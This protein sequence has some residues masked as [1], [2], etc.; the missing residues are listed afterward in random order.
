MRGL[1]KVMRILGKNWNFIATDVSQEKGGNGERIA[2]LYDTNKISF[3][4]IAGEIVLPFNELIQGMQFAR[5]PFC[6]AFQAGWFKFNLATVHI[7]YGKGDAEDN[8]RRQAEIK[9]L[10][11]A[12]AKRAK[13]EKSNYIVLGDFNI[14]EVDDEYMVA[15]E[16][17]GFKIPDHI[18]EHP[19]NFGAE[20]RHYDQIAFNLQLDKDMRVFSESVKASGAFDFTKS[21]YRDEDYE[22]YIPVMKENTGVDRA[23]ETAL[24]YFHSTYRIKQMS[25]HMPLWVQLKVD[26]SAKYIQKTL[27]ETLEKNK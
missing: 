16:S 13:K 27:E 18:K 2:F 8:E 5:T 25:D 12:L 11:N 3:K 26:F 23:G 6:V 19:T 4:N 7:F 9:A 24:E 1:E 20:V 21:I 10:G 22:E 15:L 14:P 17:T